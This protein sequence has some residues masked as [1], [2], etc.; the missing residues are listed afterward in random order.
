MTFPLSTYGEAVVISFQNA[1][2]VVICWRFN[3][4]NIATSVVLTVLYAAITVAML[5]TPTELQPYLM[6]ISTG[7]NVIAKVPQILSNFSNGNTGVL[8]LVTTLLQFGGN[9]ARVFTTITET[10]DP[11][12]LYS[13]VLN[14]VLNGT[15]LFQIILMSSATKKAQESAAL[16][17]VG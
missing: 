5:K 9:L 1:L 14:A 10:N 13:Y 4:T 12:T 17:K 16:K 2:L 8:S 6:I 11:A 3:K 7:T 15:I